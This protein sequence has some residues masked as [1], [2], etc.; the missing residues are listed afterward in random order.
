MTGDVEKQHTSPR[1]GKKKAPDT[2]ADA[3]P[4]KKRSSKAAAKTKADDDTAK[5]HA[6][7]TE[8]GKQEEQDEEQQQPEEEEKQA[9]GKPREQ[10][11]AANEAA[12][13]FLGWLT[14]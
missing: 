12:G 9:E 4:A 6:G 13:T 3:T 2:S 14:G 5:D 10:A 11:K 8:P 1:R 7:A